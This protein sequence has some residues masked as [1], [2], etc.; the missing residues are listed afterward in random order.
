MDDKMR[1]KNFAILRIIFGIIWL[2]DAIFKWSPQFINNFT[3]YLVDAAQGQPYIIQIWM[4]LWINII[5]INPFFFAL[6]I[7]VMETAIALS[8]LSGIFSKYAMYAGIPLSLIIWSTAEGFGG[9]YAQ[10]STDI[11]SGIIYALLFMALL[12]GSADKRLI[13]ST[14]KN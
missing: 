10:G 6:L 4:N 12:M 11:G 1:E 8:L 9:P 3:S 14:S 13:I 5:T 2:I 7:A